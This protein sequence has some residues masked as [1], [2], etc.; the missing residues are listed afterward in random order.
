MFERRYHH[1]W[2]L[3]LFSGVQF[4]LKHHRIDKF[5]HFQGSFLGWCLA[6]PLKK[7][8]MY[9]LHSDLKWKGEADWQNHHFQAFPTHFFGPFGIV[10]T[11]RSTKKWC[12]FLHTS[13]QLKSSS[14]ESRCWFVGSNFIK[15]TFYSPNSSEASFWWSSLWKKRQHV[16]YNIIYTPEVKNMEELEKIRFLGK[17]RFLSEKPIIF[18]YPFNFN[19]GGG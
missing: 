8:N 14:F 10:L 19:F 18:R 2:Y 16:Y 7:I 9:W 1:F 17:S 6:I 4:P 5:I 11:K 3:C 13:R 15:T 12:F